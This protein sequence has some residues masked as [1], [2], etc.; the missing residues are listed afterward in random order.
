MKKSI[1]FI[2]ALVSSAAVWLSCNKESG[3][4]NPK[5]AT[6]PRLSGVKLEKP[7]ILANA[8]L[9]CS[10]EFLEQ[11]RTVSYVQGKK[12]L[13][14]TAL[15]ANYQFRSATKPGKGNGGGGSTTTS[16]GTTSGGT[17][18]TTTTGDKT[19]PRV[20]IMDPQAG[21][22]FNF[23]NSNNQLSSVI[24]SAAAND[25]TKLVR[26]QV[27]IKGIVIRDTSNSAGIWP[28]S[29]SWTIVQGSY[30]WPFGDGTYDMAV[31]AWDAAGNTTISTILFS[32][33][34]TPTALPTNFPT[35]YTMTTPPNINQGGEGTCAA[36][37]SAIAYDI[38][39]Y[40]K[41]N[42]T[43]WTF[44]NMYSPE[45]IY[46]IQANNNCMD[47][48]GIGTNTNTLLTRGV[49]RWSTL[50]YNAQNGCDTLMFTDAM[51][52]E[53]YSNRMSGYYTVTTQDINMIKTKIA[54]NHPL[55]ALFQIDHNF[56]NAGPGYIWT[57]PH[58]RDGGPHSS[59]IVGFDDSKHAFLCMNSWGPN[60]GTNGN[61][62]I[63][64]DF[65]WQ[66]L[67]LSVYGYIP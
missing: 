21:Y 38:E 25:E 24:W 16:G 37:S 42:Q 4:F 22:T 8:K 54:Q 41:D 7:G 61:I 15:D 31:Q 33:N 57:F 23:S 35:A 12:V 48:S 1:I 51:R 34:T 53:A 39:R 67:T 17:T 6:E 18:T 13:D 47:G 44:D 55:I 64:Y 14:E 63:D 9:E 43:S 3:I 65:L 58:Y 62:W 60:W 2:A 32:R 19:A 59:V 5:P 26:I 49:P 36:F 20:M 45:W 28:I 46:N 66:E 52:A 30:N 50:P 11:G 40:Y 56:I 29:G 27:R 10:K